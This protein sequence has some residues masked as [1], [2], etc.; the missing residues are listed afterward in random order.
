M[1]AALDLFADSPF[2]FPFGCGASTPEAFLE[3]FQ[4]RMKELGAHRAFRLS[5]PLA[6]MPTTHIGRLQK[7]VEKER[8]ESLHPLWLDNSK[9]KDTVRYFAK[10]GIHVEV[11]RTSPTLPL[12]YRLVAMT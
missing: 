7:W 10:H 6:P 8:P 3:G 4:E 1:S 2:L 12:S 11:V 9:E 5:I